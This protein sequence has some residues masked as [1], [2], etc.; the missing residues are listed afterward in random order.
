[1]KKIYFCVL[2]AFVLFA[3]GLFLVGCG[4][5]NT[6]IENN[7]ADIRYGVFDGTNNGILATVIY[8]ERE[9]PYKAD[10]NSNILW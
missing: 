7:I 4:S 8:G 2:A 3:S 9:E 5:E 10:G 1:M 6:S